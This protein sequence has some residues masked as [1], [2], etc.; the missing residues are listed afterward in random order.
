[1]EGMKKKE[2]KTEKEL[3]EDFF[4]EEEAVKLSE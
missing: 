3:D 1:M 4:K 2:K